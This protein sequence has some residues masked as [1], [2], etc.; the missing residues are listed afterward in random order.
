MLLPSKFRI[1]VPRYSQK[2]IFNMASI[3]CIRFVVMSSGCIREL[4]VYLS[5]GD[6]SGIE[7]LLSRWRQ[8]TSVVEAEYDQLQ[9]VLI[10]RCT[11]AQLCADLLPHAQLHSVFEDWATAARKAG[12]FQVG[13]SGCS[14][15]M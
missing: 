4:Y 8:K 12:R 14:C 10:E 7:S 15:L 5:S 11:L 13:C 2:T 9:S 6:L 1:M 3:H